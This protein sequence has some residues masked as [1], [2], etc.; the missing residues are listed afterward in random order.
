MKGPAAEADSPAASPDGP[1][2]TCQTRHNKETEE[3]HAVMSIN[4]KRSMLLP[5]PQTSKPIAAVTPQ[6]FYSWT[7]FTVYKV[8]LMLVFFLW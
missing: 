6:D 1:S 8:S 3:T 4:S 2:P 5:A 7:Y